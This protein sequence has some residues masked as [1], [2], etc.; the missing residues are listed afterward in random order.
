MDKRAHMEKKVFEIEFLTAECV[1]GILEVQYKDDVYITLEEAK[2]IVDQRL[3]F[4]EDQ[5][6]PCLFRSSRLKGIDREARKY[7]FNEGLKNLNAIALVPNN[8]V[9]Q[10]ITTIVVNFER[11][12]IP[13][14]VFK[15]H[16]E[17]REWLKNYIKE[18]HIQK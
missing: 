1:N 13:W 15:K 11:P 16:E 17:A 6:Y 7:L 14:A 2:Y 10:M 5:Q 3:K 12:K 4:F 18:D 8:K 9:G